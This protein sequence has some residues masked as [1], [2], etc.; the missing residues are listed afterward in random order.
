MSTP[1]DIKLRLRCLH[2]RR[3]DIISVLEECPLPKDNAQALVGI[4][5]Q[6]DP[7]SLIFAALRPNFYM[8]MIYRMAWFIFRLTG[9]GPKSTNFDQGHTS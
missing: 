8:Y 9:C 5:F 1:N 3:Y 4:A 2:M 6:S 7:Q